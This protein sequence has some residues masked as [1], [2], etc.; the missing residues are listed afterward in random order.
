VKPKNSVQTGVKVV[1]GYWLI[2]RSVFLN[3]NLKQ[4]YLF[5]LCFNSMK[6]YMKFCILYEICIFGLMEYIRV[7]WNLSCGLEN[8]GIPWLCS[9]IWSCTW[10]HCLCTFDWKHLWVYAAYWF[11][12][13]QSKNMHKE[14]L[15]KNTKCY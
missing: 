8:F 15:N 7:E 5:R 12:M 3:K 14:D 4:M 6:F 11:W 13:L 10:L 1:T 2:D 9:S